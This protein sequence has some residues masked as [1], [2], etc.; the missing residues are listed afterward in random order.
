MTKNLDNLVSIKSDNL[1]Q[2][3]AC[4]ELRTNLLDEYSKYI[5]LSKEFQD[6]HNHENTRG[7]TELN[8]AFEESKATF[9]LTAEEAVGKL[10][11][12]KLFTV[13]NSGLKFIY[14]FQS[15]Q[16]K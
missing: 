4:D 15:L 5:S 7:S 9:Y 16:V 10:A 12:R 3:E 6:F 2:A 8:K 11:S 14:P 13:S 1:N